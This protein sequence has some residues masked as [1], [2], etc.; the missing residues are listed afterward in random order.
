MNAFWLSAWLGLWTTLILLPMALLIGRA[1]ALSKSRWKPWIE[2]VLLLPLVLPPTV[3]GYYFLVTFSPATG[4]GQLLQNLLGFPLV[5]S[6]QGLVM[7]SVII[8]LPFAILPIQQAYTAVPNEIREAAWVSG[9]SRLSTWWRIELPLSWP[10]ILS[11][12][13]LVFAHTLGEFGVVLMV[14]G[15]IEGS[16]RT[17]SIAIY[18]SVQGFDM[19]TAGRYSLL[20]LIFSLLSLVAMR[21]NPGRM[22]ASRAKPDS[23]GR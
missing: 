7:A 19:Q 12:M 3:I 23:Y 10:G 5:F 13:A 2:S 21:L 20:L 4:L 11:A 15:N 18:D 17:L 1:L 8:N 9:L 6:F 22:R 14:G 16:T